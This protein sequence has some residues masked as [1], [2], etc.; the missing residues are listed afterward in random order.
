MIFSLG[1]EQV[2]F[3][4]SAPI[5]PFPLVGSE[6]IFPLTCVEAPGARGAL[7]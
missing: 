4:T 1:V 2:V 6:D 5:P 7:M 3:Q